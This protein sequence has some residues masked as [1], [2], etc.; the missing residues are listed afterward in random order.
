MAKAKKSNAK[1][2]E[3][4][5]AATPVQ[6]SPGVNSAAGN[7][8]DNNPDSL[9]NHLDSVEHSEETHKA[10]KHYVKAYPDAKHFLIASDGQ[11]FL[12]AN[13]SDAKTH[14]KTLDPKKELV[15][16]SV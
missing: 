14:Q 3:K 10:M 16:Y 13:H 6:P 1:A 11:V 7:N 9:D 4:I 2:P 5:K 15:K 8:L 12:P